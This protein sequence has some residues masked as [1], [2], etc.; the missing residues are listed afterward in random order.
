M[1]FF[2]SYLLFSSIKSTQ[3]SAVEGGLGKQLSRESLVLIILLFRFYSHPHVTL[4]GILTLS[5]KKMYHV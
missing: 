4:F 1:K 5:K 2:L 3:L